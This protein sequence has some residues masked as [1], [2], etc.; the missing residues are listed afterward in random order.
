MRKLLLLVLPLAAFAAEPVPAPYAAMAYLAGS[1]WQGALP[2]GKDVDTHCFNWVYGGKFLRDQH[3]VHGAG[4]EDYLGESV[5]FLDAVAHTL[6]YLYIESAG[7]SSLGT[8]E[9]SGD[10]LLFPDTS[11]QEGGH[12]QVY[13]S[14]W[15]RSGA[16][17]YDVI[18]EFKN[19]D[20]W[21]PGF[22]AHMIKIA[23]NPSPPQP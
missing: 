8:V 2:G 20:G 4:H 1:C 21:V 18:T 7:G 16:D 22:S 3:R 5:Y 19:Q 12:T 6:R 11:Y 15:Q 23:G 17:A 9:V 13:R 10:T 14:R